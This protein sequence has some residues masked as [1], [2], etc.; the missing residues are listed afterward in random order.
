M[1]GKDSDEQFKEKYDKVSYD[2]IKRKMVALIEAR[3]LPVGF[4]LD[5]ADNYYII[6]VNADRTITALAYA[7]EAG[8]KGTID[9]LNMVD[10]AYLLSD[11]ALRGKDLTTRIR[12]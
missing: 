3:G 1:L 6:R 7:E 12:E 10:L 11:R 2:D 8:V 4:I 9:D 5:Y